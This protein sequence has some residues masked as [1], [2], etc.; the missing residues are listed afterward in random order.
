[1][2]IGFGRG[3]KESDKLLGLPG[4][5]V[6]RVNVEYGSRMDSDTQA[7]VQFGC[8]SVPDDFKKHVL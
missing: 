8:M 4:R 1:M 6:V 5:L 2:G 7:C 3:L